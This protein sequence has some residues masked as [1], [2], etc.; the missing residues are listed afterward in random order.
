MLLFDIGANVG[1]WAKANIS[2]ATKIVSVEADPQTFGILINHTKGESK[3]ECIQAAITSS[4]APFIT[5]YRASSNTISTLNRDWL[6]HP[7]SRFAGTP[8][9]EI[10]CPT[11]TIDSLVE[12]YGVPDL[13]KIDVEGAEYEVLKSL[14]RPVPLL[15][16][17]WASETVTITEQCLDYLLEL[18]YTQFHLQ[19]MDSYTFK[20]D[21]FESVSSIKDKLKVMT[22]RQEWGMIWAKQ[23]TQSE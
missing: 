9:E 13:L 5:F 10:E 11:R 20:P 16:F 6:T 7:T 14:T 1:A 17:E 19:L 15:C 21:S 4:A 3:I 2:S 22:P 12:Q 8:F 23:N 18:G